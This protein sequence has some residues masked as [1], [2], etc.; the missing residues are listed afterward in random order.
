MTVL[1]CAAYGSVFLCAGLLFRNPIVPAAV[2]LLWESANLF[3]PATLQKLGIIYYLQ[4]LC[5]LAAAPDSSMPAPLTLLI[6]ATPSAS[7]PVA[8]ACLI[9]FTLAVL[10]YSGRPVAETRNQLQHRLGWKLSDDGLYEISVMSVPLLDSRCRFTFNHLRMRC[11]L[12]IFLGLLA[13]CATYHP[14]PISPEKT[15]AD[16]DARSLADDQSARVSGNQ[17]RRRSWSAAIR[18]I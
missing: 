5:P 12:I 1:A 15:A 8:L 17:P 4:S 6:S 11:W 13:G 2:V 16:F 14:Q 7:V 3:L 18:G 10:A 9:L